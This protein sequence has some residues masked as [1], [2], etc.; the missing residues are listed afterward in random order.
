MP[1]N[2][3]YTKH[4]FKKNPCRE[5]LKRRLFS[6][7]EVFQSTLLYIRKL[8]E[9]ASNSR[10]GLG[11]GEH[12]ITMISYDYAVTYQLDD[13]RTLQFRCVDAS[14]TRLHAL[15]EEIMDLAYASCIVRNSQCFDIVSLIDHLTTTIKKFFSAKSLSVNWKVSTSKHSSTRRIIFFHTRSSATTSNRDRRKPPS[16]VT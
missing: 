7:N 15:K 4:S 11:D 12:G 2:I 9:R 10:T 6:V 16:C 1:R 5:Y 3:N 14:L 13:F 8:C